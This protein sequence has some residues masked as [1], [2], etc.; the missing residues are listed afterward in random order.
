MALSMILL[1]YLILKISAQLEFPVFHEMQLSKG[2]WWSYPPHITN[3]P[4]CIRERLC[5]SLLSWAS[6]LLGMWQSFEGG[7]GNNSMLVNISEWQLPPLPDPNSQ[8]PTT[9]CPEEDIHCRFHHCTQTIS[10]YTFFDWESW[11]FFST[12]G[13]L[14]VVTVYKGYP[15]TT[16]TPST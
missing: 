2:S 9:T 4:P 5:R 6:G 1:R 15:S 11:P 10:M 3:T 12:A 8:P 16:Y 13:A 14:V 7:R